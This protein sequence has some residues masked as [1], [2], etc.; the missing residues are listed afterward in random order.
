MGKDRES[1]ADRLPRHCAVWMNDGVHECAVIGIPS[2]QWGEAV[3]AIVVPR[4]GFAI[5][6]DALLAHCRSQLAGYECPKTV[7]VR[8]E[9]LPKSGPGKI[10]KT[11]LRKPFWANQSRSIH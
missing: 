8:S 9:E 1:A 2:E 11:E 7:D 6:T 10:L 5:D 4:A 3:H